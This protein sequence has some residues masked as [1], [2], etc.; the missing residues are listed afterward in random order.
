MQCLNSSANIT[1]LPPLTAPFGSEQ[2]ES[3][4]IPESGQSY[5]PSPLQPRNPSALESAPV[6]AGHRFFATAIATH[7]I[8]GHGICSSV[9][10]SSADAY[11]GI[12]WSAGIARS[13]TEYRV[14][15]TTLAVE[16]VASHR[17][18]GNDLTA[19]KVSNH[20]IYSSPLTANAITGRPFAAVY[21]NG[22]SVACDA[23]Q[24][25]S[26]D[27]VGRQQQQYIGNDSP[28]AQTIDAIISRELYLDS[29]T[30]HSHSA[31]I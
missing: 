29:R 1:R 22:Q 4:H 31:I 16:A 2:S 9:D 7:S 24:S 10:F 6:I 12:G 14:C 3:V 18:G 20:G 21:G 30:N 28:F 23:H 17:V 13:V 8:T 25:Q 5:T 11:L 15:D 26:N 19:S 27:T